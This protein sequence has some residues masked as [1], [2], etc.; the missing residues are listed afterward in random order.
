[1]NLH[2]G[3]FKNIEFSDYLLYN[4]YMSY[5]ERNYFAFSRYLANTDTS[6]I[7]D[8]EVHDGYTKKFFS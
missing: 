6:E 7:P 5:G 2:R 4:I 8:F 1:M 3:F